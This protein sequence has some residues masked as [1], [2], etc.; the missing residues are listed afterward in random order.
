[1]PRIGHATNAICVFVPLGTKIAD[2]THADVIE[3]VFDHVAAGFPSN[4]VAIY[5]KLIRIA[6]T[7]SFIVRSVSGG[8]D[9]GFSTGFSCLWFKAADGNFYYRLGVAN[10]DWDVLATGYCR[11]I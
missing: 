9:I 4:T 1:M 11:A 3:H 2:I 8:T 10:D 5:I 6:G 7:G